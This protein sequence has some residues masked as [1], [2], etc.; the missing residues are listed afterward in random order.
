MRLI[1]NLAGWLFHTALNVASRWKPKAAKI[2]RGRRESL[3]RIQQS[4]DPNKETI[5][6]HVSSLGEYEQA[7]PLIE[8][9]RTH[10][11]KVQLVLSFFSS[12]GYEVCKESRLVD[13]VIYL[14]Q[15][16]KQAMSQLIDT[17]KP[18]LVFFLK[19]DLWP[20]LLYELKRR[21][22]ACYLVAA[23]F[24]PTQLF[25]KPWGKW[26]LKLLDLFS[27]IYVQD[28]SSR[29]L[30]LA[31]HITQVRVAHDTRF[32]RVLEVAAHPK[33]IPIIEKLANNGRLT[34]IAGSSWDVDEAFLCPYFLEHDINMV[35]APHEID[36]EHLE[37][38]E[39]KLSGRSFRLSSL[40][41]ETDLSDKTCI[42]VDSFGLL[43]SLY[44]F[45]DIVYIGGGFGRGIHNTLEAAVYGVPLIFGPRNG[46]FREARDLIRIG[47]AIELIEET[48]FSSCMDRLCVDTPLRLHM[49]AL[50]KDYVWQHKGGVEEILSHID[51]PWEGNKSV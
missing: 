8:T 24:R 50:A 14:P 38:I 51:I 9:F 3:A 37:R 13:V 23:I 31:H 41:E 26:Y 43:S 19:Y 15:D 36:P 20:N 32:D 34:L 10:Y 1:Y 12:S 39:K 6:F 4:I 47:A 30:L 25:F 29:E 45:A 40:T 2:V 42:I 48:S 49:A 21:E 27:F 11:P 22:I 17:M 44:R 35:I 5:W 33:P 28:E 18:D 16:T 46:K 7:R